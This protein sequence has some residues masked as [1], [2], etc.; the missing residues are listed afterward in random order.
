MNIKKAPYSSTSKVSK[1][2]AIEDIVV[3]TQDLDIMS[4]VEG[5]PPTG[6]FYPQE[7]SQSAT[8]LDEIN[9]KCLIIEMD[10]KL[11]EEATK[12]EED[13]KFASIS[14]S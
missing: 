7:K 8:K 14:S 3:S 1:S 6:D 13:T 11:I 9:N 2:S 4:F 5:S 10:L 12:N